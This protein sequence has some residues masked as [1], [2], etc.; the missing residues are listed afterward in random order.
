LKKKRLLKEEGREEDP[1]VPRIPENQHG[2]KG[3]KKKGCR[4]GTVPVGKRSGEGEKRVSIEKTLKKNVVPVCM[5]GKRK[6]CQKSSGGER[7]ET[8]LPTNEGR[9]KKEGDGEERGDSGAV[10]AVGQG[11]SNLTNEPTPQTAVTS[12]KTNVTPA[13]DANGNVK[14]RAPKKK[15]KWKKRKKKFV[16]SRLRTT[17]GNSNLPQKVGGRNGRIKKKKATT[18]PGAAVKGVKTRDGKRMQKQEILRDK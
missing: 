13:I 14:G 12:S 11:N 17:G 9:E 7:T 4:H 1:C 15:K 18:N 10:A 6:E 16:N 2:R 3:K 8:S 5:G